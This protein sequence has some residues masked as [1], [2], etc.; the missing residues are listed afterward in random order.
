MDAPDV[1]ETVAS[2]SRL[3]T[4]PT[5]LGQILDAISDPDSSAL[6]L[7]RHIA[8]DQSLSATLL[9]QVNSAYYGF[10]RKITNV[11]DAIVI[12]GYREVQ[13]LVLAASAFRSFPRGRSPY[14]RNQLWRHSLAT[15]IGAERLIK[16][17]NLTLDGSFFSAGLLHDIGKVALDSVYPDNFQEAVKLA[18]DRSKPLWE[19]EPEIFGLDHAEIGGVLAEHWNL[20]PVLAEALRK[21][22][23]PDTALLAPDLTHVTALANHLTYEAGL[24]EASN[25]GAHAFP[26]SSARHINAGTDVCRHIVTE[27]QGAS[28]RINAMLGAVAGH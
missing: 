6:D 1:R 16:K 2:I 17:L 3:P 21:H 19:V 14:D 25:P 5:V 24:G 7:G 4:L 27:L 9:R 13:N 11:T 18:V 15:A 8:A 10:Y 22:H 28:D 12:L 20:P 26:V 23:Q